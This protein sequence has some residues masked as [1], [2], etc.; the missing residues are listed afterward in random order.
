MKRA[1]LFDF[2][3]TLADSTR[4]V[5]E[6]INYALMKMGL[7]LAEHQAIRATIGLSLPA[8]LAQLTGLTD[9]VLAK[10]FTA[11]FVECADLRMVELTSIFPNASRA[12]HD[13][14]RAGLKTGIVSTKYRY[15]IEAI[16]ARDGLTGHFDVIVGGEDVVRHKPEPEGLYRA[17]ERIGTSG[18]DTVYVGDH[19]VDAMAASAAGIPFVAVLTGN[20]V[21]RDFDQWPDTLFIE[22]LPDLLPLLTT[23]RD[24]QPRD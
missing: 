2:D 8:T 4:G 24:S 21:R 12:V 11:N 15:R 16:L 13:L 9:L 19:P 7:P 18:P 20:A 1:V 6:C 14:R 17:I 10:S 5:I 3:L 23:S 22:S